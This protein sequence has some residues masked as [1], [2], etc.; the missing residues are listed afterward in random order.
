VSIARRFALGP[1][2][3][4]EGSIRA[5]RQKESNSKAALY[6]L[7][8][9]SGFTAKADKWGQQIAVDAFFNV[10]KEFWPDVRKNVFG[11]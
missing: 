9:R 10:A 6:P 2:T 8:E 4:R 3:L 11:R 5:L 1:D 7:P